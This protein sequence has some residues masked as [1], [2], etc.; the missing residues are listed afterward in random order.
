MIKEKVR[1]GDLLI[2]KGVI[3]EEELKKA[4]E[5]QKE[6]KED[7]HYKKLGEI[8]IELGLASEKQIL[9]TLSQQL[10]HPFV[11][12]Y[13]EDIDYDLMSSYPLAL[14]EKNKIVPFKQDEEYL[15]IATADPLD[16]DSLELIEKMSPKTLKVFIALKKDIQIIIER[17]KIAISTQTLVSKVRKE[18]KVGLIEGISAIEELLDLIIQ[19]AVKKRATDI[20]IEPLKYNF[21][22][23]SRTDG[24]LMELFSFDK[25]IYYPLVSKIKLLSNLDISE[26]RKPQDGRFNKVYDEKVYDFR[27]STTPTLH[28]ESVVLRI[29]DQ[30]KILLRMVEL[31]M[32]EYNLEKFE[33]LIKSPYGIVFVTGPTGSGK[34]TTL[35]AALN[36]VKGIDKKIITIEDPVEYEI[37][38]IQQIPINSKIGLTF[39][40]VLR[41][42]LR[43]DPDIIMIGEVRD[44]ETLEASIQA[45][46]TGHLVFA[47]L[48]TNDAIS[49]ITRMI[50]MGA[51]TY[52]VADSLIGVV[53]QRLVRRIC[54]YCK[55]E[56]IP[57][58]D[59]LKFIEPFL[60]ED[61]KFFKGKGCKECHFSGYLGREMIS[62][63]LVVNNEI[64]HLIATSQDKVKIFK[65]AKENGFISM[66]EDG[67]YKLK[68]GITTLE[69][70]LR[71]VK[72]DVF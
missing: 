48:H 46:L 38:L 23:R 64:S 28:G 24:V 3:T 11:D 72:V 45:S 40:A 58:K 54:P 7:G 50:Q 71:V 4:L 17:L 41:N 43:Q 56:Y 26:K 29:L 52:M 5:K 61:M 12:L 20:H 42:I 53:A 65:A 19:T 51:Q 22:V 63:I 18:L 39:S 10:G 44:F 60:E 55:E 36:E 68:R 67:M 57:T 25:D 30:D 9:E 34:T 2:Q 47:T 62:E 27:V 49:S 35:Y 37:P 33:K 13:G 31:G 32:S 14:I 15:Y 70:I 8:L 6:Y 1:L 21:I 66:L 59:E 69:E 16:Y